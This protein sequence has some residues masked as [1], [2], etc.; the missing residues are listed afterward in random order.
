MKITCIPTGYLGT[1]TYLILGKYQGKD[2]SL[3]IDPAG[4]T[5]K[6]KSNMPPKLT[7]IIL[8]HGHF[9]HILGMEDM[10][11]TGEKIPVYA[12]AKEVPLLE[13]PSLNHSALIGKSC[14]VKADYLLKDGE[15]VSISSMKFRAMET[16]GHSVGSMCYYFEE[17]DVLFSGD[18]LFF[19]SVGRTDFPTGDAGALRMSVTEKLFTL[20]DEVKVYPGHGDFTTIGH[21]KMYNPYFRSV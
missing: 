10:L 12:C 16:P 1:N 5:D 17:D 6:L 9:D 8:T 13:D 21:E 2:Y 14:V 19:E 3:L 7:A 18:T 15:E 11:K 4:I 20:K